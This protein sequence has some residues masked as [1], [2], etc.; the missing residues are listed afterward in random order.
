MLVVLLVL[1]L[2]LLRRR[3][4]RRRRRRLAAAA[5]IAKPRLAI[6]WRHTAPQ[7]WYLAVQVSAPASRMIGRTG[8]GM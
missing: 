7:C 4:R 8:P 3:R 1:V 2:L 6:D 5:Q